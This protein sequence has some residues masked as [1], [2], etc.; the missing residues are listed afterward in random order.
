MQAAAVARSRDDRLTVAGTVAGTPGFMAPE[1][2]RG[3][4]VDERA[5]VF[6]LGAT[7]FFVLSGAFLYDST[8]AT[9]MVSLAS[10]VEARLD[11]AAGRRSRPTCGRSS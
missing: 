5:D 9:E 3:E 11:R 1:Q 7:L 2:A 8:S 6:A 4:P 10:S